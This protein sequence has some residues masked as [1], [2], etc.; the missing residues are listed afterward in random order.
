MIKVTNL[1]TYRG[2]TSIYLKAY[3]KL[4]L[5]QLTLNTFK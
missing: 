3:F 5:T 1:L 2:I 4:D